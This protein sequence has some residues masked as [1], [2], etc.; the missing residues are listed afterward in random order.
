MNNDIDEVRRK[1]LADLQKKY[2]AQQKREL[3]QQIRLQ[4]QIELLESIAKQ[5]MTKEAISRYGNLKA[6]HPDKAIQAIAIIAQA[7]E[8]G[9]LKEKLDDESFKKLLQELTPEKREF[10]FIRK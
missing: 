7:V 8:S 9:Q 6:A 2:L 3:Q 4:Q 5:F 1:K 10:K